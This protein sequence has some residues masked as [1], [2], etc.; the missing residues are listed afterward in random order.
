[1]KEVSN[2]IVYFIGAGPGDPELMTL[3]GQKLL[4]SADVVLYAGSLVPAE[5]LK[6]APPGAQSQNSAGMKLEQQIALM[7]EAVRQGKRV[8]RLHT[9]DPSIYG[10][11]AEQMQAL[12]RL[13]IP[14]R[15]VP[16]VSS[17]FAAAAALGVE[18]TLPDST[19]TLI[20][21]RMSG[22]TPLPELE[23]L[24]SLAAHHSS[25]VVFLST[26]LVR[27][28]IRELR[29]AGYSPETPVALVYRAS[30]PDERILR[31]TLDDIAEQAEAQELTHQ[32]L[33]IVSPALKTAALQASH[34]YGGFQE[35]PAQRE[36]TA[37]LTLT[38]P[39]IRLGRTFLAHLPDSTLYMP[40]RLGEPQDSRQ[41]NIRL[42]YESIRQVLQS[43]FMEYESLVCIMASGIV[44]RE[45]APVLKNKHSDPAVVVMDAEGRFAVSLLS[46]HEGGANR[47]ALR[48]AEIAGGQAVITTA[49]DVQKI[50]ALD[51]LAKER[52]WI[53]D[54][55]SNLA[56]V[57]AGLVN[58]EPVAL[59]QDR[60]CQWMTGP[61]TAALTPCSSWMDAQ[62]HGLQS[63]FAVTFR[64]S[65]PGVW[66][67]FANL[68]VYYPPALVVGVGCNRNTPAGEIQEAVET[69]LREAGLAR[70]SV[71]CLASVENKAD[72]AGLLEVSARNAW[73]LKIVTRQQILEIGELPNPSA[74]V[75]KALGVPGVA[76][77]AS[78]LIAKSK[79]L[80]VGKRKFGNVTV[81]VALK[82]ETL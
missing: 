36:G 68:V 73:P 48:L 79:A 34:L 52:G 71:S 45:L 35:H 17:A 38:A 20:L 50:P 63:L 4:A 33:I 5:M 53:L 69:V 54:P 23:N 2:G 9:G 18:Y 46:G 56:A 11:I 24:R 43:A 75:K 44:V 70:E 27:E 16:G 60:E 66:P 31:G 41:K 58:G 21:T 3:K 39:S 29:A 1:M 25:L 42:F 57:M 82:K 26:G 59:V 7:S 67:A 55:R 62:Q 28:V 10:A 74:Q 47:L 81:A 30:W 15:V 61:E 12:D 51:V 22:R 32:G 76:E 40:Q 77:P 19:Q 49:S 72:E 64:A 37:I 8:V 14:Y 65:P 13:G 78:L 6:Y 80:L